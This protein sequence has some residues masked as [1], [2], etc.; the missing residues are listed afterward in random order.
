VYDHVGFEV[1]GL[2]EFCRQLEAKGIK[3]TKAYRK[4]PAMNNVGTASMVD[5]WG[6]SIELTEGLRDLQ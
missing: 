4:D 3:L 1:R 5:P 6:V 2:E